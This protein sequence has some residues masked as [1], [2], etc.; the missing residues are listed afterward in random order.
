MPEPI[1]RL[2]F[3]EGA[4]LPFKSMDVG[5]QASAKPPKPVPSPL[6]DQDTSPD[7]HIEKLVD[8]E[9]AATD[10]DDLLDN[11]RPIE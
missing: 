1:Y 9:R 10:K 3:D 2:R 6:L 11:G 8:D 5:T 7:L 4:P